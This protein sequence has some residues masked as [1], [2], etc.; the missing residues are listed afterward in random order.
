MVC[1]DSLCLIVHFES[2]QT[3]KPCVVILDFPD[4]HKARIAH[5]I[6]R[7]SLFACSFRKR[8]RVTGTCV[9]ILYFPEFHKERITRGIFRCSMFDYCFRKE[10]NKQATTISWIF[11][12]ILVFNKTESV[13]Y[14]KLCRTC[15][16]CDRDTS[17]IQMI[18]PSFRFATRAIANSVWETY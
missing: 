5:G 11:N 16:I 4:F 18:V 1:C 14:M 13:M 7:L 6:L 3:K 9:A 10:V 17:L 2:K 15:S 8:K 12:S